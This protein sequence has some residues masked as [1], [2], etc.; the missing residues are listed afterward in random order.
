VNFLG[1]NNPST[2]TVPF[3]HRFLKTRASQTSLAGLLCAVIAVLLAVSLPRSR[4]LA[5]APQKEDQHP[6]VTDFPQLPYEGSPPE[7]AQD[8][9]LVGL[10]LMLRRLG[11]TAQLM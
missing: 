3:L 5:A 6:S 1:R 8:E 11:T 9:G 4:S 2:R 10:R 7:I